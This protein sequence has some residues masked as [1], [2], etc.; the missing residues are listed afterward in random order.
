MSDI[1]SNTLQKTRYQPYWEEFSC[2]CIENELLAL[3]ASIET[4]AL[5]A[6]E[7]VC[8]RNRSYET[9]RPLL[10][11]IRNRHIKQRLPSP[12]DAG[13]LIDIRK[14]LRIKNQKVSPDKRL[15]RSFAGHDST[16]IIRL[17]ND[18]CKFQRWCA[19]SDL[20]P[21]PADIET[22]ATYLHHLNCEQGFSL[23]SLRGHQM[24][25]RIRH[26][27]SGYSSYCDYPE[28]VKIIKCTKSKDAMDIDT[29]RTISI[30]EQNGNAY[31]NCHSLRDRALL[32]LFTQLDVRLSELQFLLWKYVS[33]SDNKTLMT[34][35]LRNGVSFDRRRSI[36][37]NKQDKGSQNCVLTAMIEWQHC[38]NTNTGFVFRGIHRSGTMYSD[39]PLSETS[40]TKILRKKRDQISD[41]D[42]EK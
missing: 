18:W 22:L 6:M 32:M 14:Y 17:E 8:R 30:G 31:S 12:C 33:F 4:V 24:A 2:W 16:Y 38:C 13:I 40:L 11:A 5:F 1:S 27:Y 9:L 23:K 41:R 20:P 10:S 26:R 37:V 35:I 39:K 3:P 29:E 42:T 28:L 15:V 36:V 25:I 7:R 21:L 19:E 34:L